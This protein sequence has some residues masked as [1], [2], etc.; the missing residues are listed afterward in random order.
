MGA[1][2]VTEPS[3]DVLFCFV[4]FLAQVTIALRFLVPAS[5]RLGFSDKDFACV[6]LKPLRNIA[7]P[8]SNHTASATVRCPPKMKSADAGAQKKEVTL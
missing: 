7:A 4:P 6:P 3:Y 1:A 5:N 8:T 2:G